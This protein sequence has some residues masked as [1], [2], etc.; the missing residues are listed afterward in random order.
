M[1]YLKESDANFVKKNRNPVDVTVR[2]MYT[3]FGVTLL[4][5][6][7]KKLR[8][9]EYWSIDPL[10]STPIFASIMK[11]DRFF[12]ILQ[13]FHL[14]DNKQPTNGDKLYKIRYVVDYLKKKFREIFTPFQ[15]L[16]ID[17]SLVLFKGR[18]AF[19]QYIPSKRH[20]FGIKLFMLCDSK[21]R[22]CLDFIVYT[23]ATTE[24]VALP[25]ERK[26][27]GKSGQIVMTLMEGYFKKNT[28]FI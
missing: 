4:M 22:V 24:V 17:E 11:R 27:I 19:R 26:E 12:L 13:I 18:L 28:H 16:S 10:I 2:E 7:C 8:L 1:S 21:R 20:R 15:K 3:F 23:G 25:K 6:R 14:C 5:T 9:H